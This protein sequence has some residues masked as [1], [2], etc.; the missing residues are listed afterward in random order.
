MA[1]VKAQLGHGEKSLA[2]DRP[3][4]WG[5]AAAHRPMPKHSAIVMPAEARPDT[6]ARCSRRVLAA[7]SRSSVPAAEA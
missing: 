6:R 1:D 5:F 7:M 3:R 4:N 2:S